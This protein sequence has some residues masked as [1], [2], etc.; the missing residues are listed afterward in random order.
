MKCLKADLSF[1]VR[2]SEWHLLIEVLSQHLANFY[3]F[4]FVGFAV[5]VSMIPI[6]AVVKQDSQHVLS[7]RG[8]QSH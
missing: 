3:L 6:Y 5:Y 4:P 7:E 8:K 2:N 1:Q